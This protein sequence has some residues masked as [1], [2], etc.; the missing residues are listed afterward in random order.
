MKLELNDSHL[1]VNGTIWNVDDLFRIEEANLVTEYANQAATYAH[2]STLVAQAEFEAAQA[3]N[4]KDMEYAAADENWRKSLQEIGEKFTE[5]SVRSLV[6]QDAEYQKCVEK[7]LETQRNFKVLRALARALEQRADMLVSMGA[8]LRA[9]MGMTGMS[10]KEKE[11]Q[12]NMEMMRQTLQR[13][14]GQV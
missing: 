9:E 7:A 1:T 10:L 6:L 2:F 5:A 13:R 11:L 8:H 14:K 12:D 3:E 4:L